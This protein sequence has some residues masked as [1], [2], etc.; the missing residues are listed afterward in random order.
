MTKSSIPNFVMV[1]SGERS[2]SSRT[3]PV[4]GAYPAEATIDGSGYAQN[5]DFERF[6]LRTYCCKDE[7]N[8]NSNDALV[9]VPD[10]HRAPGTDDITLN[11]LSRC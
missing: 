10:N 7:E 11:I 6:L 2:E 9:S 3:T 5:V 1:L 8:E 4:A